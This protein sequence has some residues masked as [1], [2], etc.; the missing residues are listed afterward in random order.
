M[1]QGLAYVHAALRACAKG[2][3]LAQAHLAFFVQTGILL[4]QAEPALIKSEQAYKMRSFPWSLSIKQKAAS[5]L[6]R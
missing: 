6:S 2:N 4:N 1:S 3:Y 5:P